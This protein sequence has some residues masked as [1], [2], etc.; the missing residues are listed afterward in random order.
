M[1]GCVGRLG[2]CVG[3]LIHFHGEELLQSL[4]V[5][6]TRTHTLGRHASALTAPV[7]YSV[8]ADGSDSINSAAELDQLVNNLVFRLKV[9]FSVILLMALLS[10][11]AACCDCLRDI[12]FCLAR[13]QSTSVMAVPP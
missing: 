1:T 2:E 7:A 13:S 11:T 4:C 6:H 12:C 3:A 9:T 5:P 10:P 8:D